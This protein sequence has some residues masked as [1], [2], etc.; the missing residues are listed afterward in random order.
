MQE[1]ARGSKKEPLSFFN[2]ET[3]Q[4]TLSCL[5]PQVTDALIT[6]DTLCE[7]EWVKPARE[8]GNIISRLLSKCTPGAARSICQDGI[9]TASHR[10]QLVRPRLRNMSSNMRLL[11]VELQQAKGMLAKVGQVQRAKGL[12][13]FKSHRHTKAT[14]ASRKV[15]WV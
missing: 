14:T 15:S 8:R 3:C 9:S 10:L 2:L 6:I 5:G 4:Q 11:G 12:R 1:Q 13:G 7:E